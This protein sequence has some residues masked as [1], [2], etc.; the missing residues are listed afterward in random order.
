MNETPAAGAKPGLPMVG[1]IDGNARYR[2]E[3]AAALAQYY[4]VIDFPD[5]RDAV[6][7]LIARPPA[8]IIV[9]ENAPPGGGMAVLE[10]VRKNASLAGVPVIAKAEDADTAFAVAAKQAPDCTVLSKPFKRSQLL[11]AI[12]SNV[13]KE[14]EAAWDK[15]EPVQQAA[16]KQ[17]VAAFNE[18]A[19][20]LEDGKP[21]PFAKVKE[22]CA[23]LARAVADGNFK[24]ALKGVRGHDNYTYVHSMR[25]ATI[26]SLFGHQIG[27]RGDDLLTLATGGLLH[28]VG[29]MDV[30]QDVL[31]KPGRLT[32]EEFAV[33]K[34]HVTHTS[35]HLKE[36]PGIPRGVTTIAEQHHE[37]LNG[38]GYP[39]G[40]QGTQ[41]N[42]LARMAAIT[43]I[44][45]AL[46]DRRVYKPPVPPEKSLEIMEGMTN[47]LDQKL[48]A[49][50]RG[51]LLDA[52]Q[53]T[54]EA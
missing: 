36:S 15:I 52:A 16:L 20:L 38:K 50:F 48:L 6:I 25:V 4:Q 28:D 17:S 26:L 43:D 49:M 32:D 10:L 35:R 51:M 11:A 7:G 29:K 47:E 53:G 34:S 42:E 30:P 46:T 3:I 21:I 33:M 23:P 1:L 31:N 5:A 8:V 44:F 54:F 41:L 2:A 22:S 24:D 39:L 14:I 12:S 18:I 37:K 27:I 9:D 19:G 45:S 13:N 40:L